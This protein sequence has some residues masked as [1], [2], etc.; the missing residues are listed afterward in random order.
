M[1]KRSK[2]KHSKVIIQDSEDSDTMLRMMIAEQEEDSPKAFVSHGNYFDELAEDSE[3]EEGIIEEGKS[4]P[5]RGDCSGGKNVRNGPIF[6]QIPPQKP[7][8]EAS[9]PVSDLAKDQLLL[10]IRNYKTVLEEKSSK[11]KAAL[12]EKD[13]LQERSKKSETLQNQLINALVK[14]D[15]LSDKLS[16]RKEKYRA[17]LQEA[18]QFLVER[19]QLRKT[20]VYSQHVQ[21]KVAQMKAV[22]KDL[23][24]SNARLRQENA[25]LQEQ[26]RTVQNSKE[27]AIEG[28][29]G[30]LREATEALSKLSKEKSDQL[31]AANREIEALKQ[32]L[33][34]AREHE[35]TLSSD[36]YLYQLHKLRDY[37]NASLEVCQG[38]LLE[39]LE[40]AAIIQKAIQ[41]KSEAAKCVVCLEGARKVLLLPCAHLILCETCVGK[42][43]FCPICRARIVTRVRVQ[44]D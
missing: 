7:Y 44:G 28:I 40:K 34:P 26:M 4:E 30:K 21:A 29:K 16:R 33:W 24:E 12:Q 37:D 6:A 42:V 8:Q 43:N 14:V 13:R 18:E 23:T 36:L 19:D 22:N 3:N 17:K 11:L 25:Y 27:K 10:Q 2:P 32:D 41:R 15:E 35:S 31:R 1:G 39:H 9:V 5:I 20:E 38:L